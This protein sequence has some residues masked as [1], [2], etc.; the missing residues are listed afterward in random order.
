[1]AKLK[2]NHGA[3]SSPEQ[4]TSFPA[5]A[6]SCASKDDLEVRARTGVPLSRSAELNALAHKVASRRNLQDV[7]FSEGWVEKLAGDLAKFND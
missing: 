3:V 2:V 5:T 7:E 1:M 6:T 4:G